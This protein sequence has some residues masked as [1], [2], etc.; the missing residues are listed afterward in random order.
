MVQKQ[1]YGWIQPEV[2]R[3]CFQWFEVNKWWTFVDFFWLPSKFASQ[4]LVHLKP[5]Q[6]DNLSHNLAR[7]PSLLLRIQLNRTESDAEFSLMQNFLCFD[8]LQGIFCFPESAWNCDSLR[9]SYSFRFVPQIKL[10]VTIVWRRIQTR[11]LLLQ[12]LEA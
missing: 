5:T 12:V 6:E 11:V 3:E 1:N 4:L 7:L 9:F 8:I 10:L 2:F